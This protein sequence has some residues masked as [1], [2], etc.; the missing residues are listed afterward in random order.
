MARIK[1]QEAAGL[2]VKRGRPVGPRPAPSKADLVKLYVKEEQSVR[3]VA[4]VLGYSK[5]AVHRGLKQYGIDARP[6][7]SRSRL[8]TIPLRNLKAA[9]RAKGISGTARDLLK[10]SRPLLF[11]R[12]RATGSVRTRFPGLPHT[13]REKGDRPA[14]ARKGP[15]PESPKNRA[16]HFAQEGRTR[17]G[18][19][20]TPDNSRPGDFL[21]TA[22]ENPLQSSNKL[23]LL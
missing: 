18:E 2:E 3:D 20:K 22:R 11:E 12:A 19:Y 13:L 1:Y 6:N 17:A 5:D 16:S 15:F 4:A 9:I 8:R 14:Q 7:A 10:S 23:L 21:S